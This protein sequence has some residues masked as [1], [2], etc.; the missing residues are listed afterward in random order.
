MLLPKWWSWNP[1]PSCCCHHEV[2]F[3]FF[4]PSSLFLWLPKEI[5]THAPHLAPNLLVLLMG[6]TLNQSSSTTTLV[7]QMVE[8]PSLLGLGQAPLLHRSKAADTHSRSSNLWWQG[9][10]S[11]FIRLRGCPHIPSLDMWLRP[12]PPHRTSHSLGS[13]PAAAR[14]LLFPLHLRIS[15]TLHVAPGTNKEICHILPPT[16]PSHHPAPTTPAS[17][18]NISNSLPFLEE[19]HYFPGTRGCPGARWDPSLNCCRARPPLCPPWGP[20]GSSPALS[21]L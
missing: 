7:Q 14:R 21:L 12:A 10:K 11:A 15:L 1:R 17:L 2:P 18:P 5:R 20:A 6:G 16:S 13:A 9:G 8:G 19:C 4:H 3:P